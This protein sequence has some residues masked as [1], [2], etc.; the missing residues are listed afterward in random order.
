VNAKAKAQE[1]QGEILHFIW[2]G[3]TGQQYTVIDIGH[4]FSDVTSDRIR[5]ALHWLEAEGLLRCERGCT[6]KSSWDDNDDGWSSERYEKRNYKFMVAERP[7]MRR[8]PARWSITEKGIE[9]VMEA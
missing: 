2:L 4:E 3:E 5:R 8:T 7:T 1:L 6:S 9:R